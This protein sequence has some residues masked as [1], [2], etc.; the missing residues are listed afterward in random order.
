MRGRSAIP[1][2][3]RAP[4]WRCEMAR[5]IRCE[6]CTVVFK[7]RRTSSR[8]C[9][10]SCSSLSTAPRRANAVHVGATRYQA[11]GYVLERFAASDETL[12]PM[13]RGISLWLP[14]HRIVMARAIGRPLESWEKV[15]HINGDR[16]DNRLENL[17]LRSGPH[18]N[19]QVA[20]CADCGSQHI[21][22]DVLA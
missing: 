6:R 18:G 10:K 9:S 19:G 15:H 5:Y 13:R 4:V 7:A 14:Q 3:P 17:Q 2:L 11:D 8:F 16:T 21:V 20:R 12:A 1:F 22:F